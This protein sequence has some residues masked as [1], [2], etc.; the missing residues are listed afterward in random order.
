MTP[1]PRFKFK[2]RFNRVPNV[3]HAMHLE[4]PGAIG[5]ALRTVFDG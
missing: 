1:M 5:D 2:T 3:G 4:A